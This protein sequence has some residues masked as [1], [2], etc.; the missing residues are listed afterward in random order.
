VSAPLVPINWG[1]AMR[2][3]CRLGCCSWLVWVLRLCCSLPAM[4][5]L[6]AIA[7]QILMHTQ[8]M[9]MCF[10]FASVLCSASD[11]SLRS[12]HAVHAASDI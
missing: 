5:T 2:A 10:V 1:A 12:A 8:H 7:K 6:P 9:F 4:Q 11:A 3:V